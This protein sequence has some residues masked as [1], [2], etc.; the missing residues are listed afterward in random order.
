MEEETRKEAAKVAKEAAK[1]EQIAQNQQ[2]L[3]GETTEAGVQT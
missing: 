3:V 1:A 2:V